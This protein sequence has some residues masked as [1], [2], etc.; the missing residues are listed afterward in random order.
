MV[1]ND[2]MTLSGIQ[3]KAFDYKLGNHGALVWVIDKYRVTRDDNGNIASDPNRL[4]DEQY[5]LRLIGQ[6]ITVS[7]ETVSIVGSLPAP[8]LP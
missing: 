8:G 1:Y 6:V 3:P 4:D 2:F 5:I 7:L